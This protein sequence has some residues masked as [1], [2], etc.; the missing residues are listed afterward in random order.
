MKVGWNCMGGENQKPP[1]LPCELID[2]QHYTWVYEVTR[3]IRVTFAYRIM[4]QNIIVLCWEPNWLAHLRP[5]QPLN[6][7]LEAFLSSLLPE[8]VLR[9]LF[10]SSSPLLALVLFS[11][12]SFTKGSGGKPTLLALIESRKNLAKGVKLSGS[13]TS[14]VW[15]RPEKWSLYVGYLR[16][17]SF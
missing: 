10:V 15:A 2:P 17:G 4:L 16:P 12:H 14:K 7:R 5:I 3:G 1:L 13:R 9:P 8:L 6:S 11:I